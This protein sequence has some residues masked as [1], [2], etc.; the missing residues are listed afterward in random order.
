MY[1]MQFWRETVKDNNFLSALILET[2]K[3]ILE[4]LRSFLYIY[5]DILFG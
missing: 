3:E 4:N 2:K 5:D 1:E